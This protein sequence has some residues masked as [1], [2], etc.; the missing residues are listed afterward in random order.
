MPITN[1]KTVWSLFPSILF[2]LP[3]VDAKRIYVFSPI[4]HRT[5]DVNKTGGQEYNSPHHSGQSGY[6]SD[7]RPQ[8]ECPPVI[9]VEKALVNS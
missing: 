3:E 4:V 8:C 1:I 9:G 5:A 6:G 2:D 7:D